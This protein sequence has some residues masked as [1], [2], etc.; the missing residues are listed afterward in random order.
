MQSNS[1]CIRALFKLSDE[2][3]DAGFC[4]VKDGK[5]RFWRVRV[6]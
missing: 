4:Y 5:N 3:Q 6:I 1:I 2:L